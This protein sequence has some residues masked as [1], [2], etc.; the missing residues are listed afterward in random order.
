MREFTNNE[1]LTILKI[2]LD[3]CAL[4]VTEKNLEEAHQIL[5]VNFLLNEFKD[6][7]S[8]EIQ[9][10]VQKYLG[11]KLQAD[12]KF[13]VKMSAEYLGAILKQYRIFKREKQAE[14]KLQLPQN[15]EVKEASAE[16]NLKILIDYVSKNNVLP[17]WGSNLYLSAYQ[18]LKNPSNDEKIQFAVKVKQRI[19][20]EINSQK[21]LNT[22]FQIKAKINELKR[23]LT[24]PKIFANVCRVHYIKDFLT[25]NYIKR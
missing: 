23:S 6:L 25:L 13:C 9:D 2:K 15:N 16:E 22:S 11:G 19:L 3:I 12:T 21:T 17:E 7:S 14:T 10:A 1:D 24:M 5:I 20:I 18:C 4:L 8:N